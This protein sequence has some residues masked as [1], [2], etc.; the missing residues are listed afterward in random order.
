MFQVKI[1]IK[2]GVDAMLKK[3][4]VLTSLLAAITL[5]PVMPMPRTYAASPQ[6][7]VQFQINNKSFVNSSGE[8]FLPT[9]PYMVHNNTMI[10]LRA[11]AESLAVSIDWNQAKQTVSLTGKSFGKLT[12]KVNDNYMYSEQGDKVKLSEPLANMN[13]TL[14]APA[15][16]LTQFIEAEMY[17]TML[18]VQSL[19]RITAIARTL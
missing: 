6:E 18:H 15:R 16:S 13:G 19:S 3:K 8:H 14:F 10:P 9:A 1:E 12:M 2:D 11:L 17:G 4:L 7:K 5:T